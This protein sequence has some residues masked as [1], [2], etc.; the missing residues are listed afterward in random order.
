MSNEKWGMSN[1][2]WGMS[3]VNGKAVIFCRFFGV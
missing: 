3:D 1:E 2:K